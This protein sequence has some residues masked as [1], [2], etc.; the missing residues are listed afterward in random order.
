MDFKKTNKQTK[1]RIWLAIQDKLFL[2]ASA[3]PI[4]A[5]IIFLWKYILKC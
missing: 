1:K 4:K 3:V 5:D 2:Q